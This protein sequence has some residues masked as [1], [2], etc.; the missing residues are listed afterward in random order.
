MKLKLFILMTAHVYSTFQ[1]TISPPPP[2]SSP[3]SSLPFLLSLQ[4]L[5]SLPL[6]PP[7]CTATKIMQIAMDR[8]PQLE[9]RLKGVS[10]ESE[11]VDILVTNSSDNA[12][13][14]SGN[15]QAGGKC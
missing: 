11:L 13:V 9:H 12:G 15:G 8:W 14:C 3:I 4:P 10:S 2:C 1:K 7:L 5:S 6:P